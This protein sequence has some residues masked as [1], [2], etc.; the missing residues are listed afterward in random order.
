[1]AKFD[2]E[3][4]IYGKEGQLHFDN[5]KQYYETV[6]ALCN[7]DIFYITYEENKKTN[8]YADAY[9]IR[10][11]ISKEKLPLPLKNAVTS[12][13][14]I[15]C[16]EFVIQLH[17]KHD[18]NFISGQKRLRADFGQVLGTIPDRYVD[19]FQKGYWLYK[20]KYIGTESDEIF[21]KES[22]KAYH[23]ESIEAAKEDVKVHQKE[24]GTEVINVF[25]SHKHDDLE[26][27]SE[28]LGF[29]EKECGVKVYID[30]RDPEMPEVTSGET[31]MRIKSRIDSCDK[32]VLLA[33]DNAIDSKWCNWELGY[34]DAK[35]RLGQDIALLPL[36][37]NK[38]DYKG[39][40]YM[41]IYPYIVENVNEDH[42]DQREKGI[43]N[44]SV[45]IPEDDH[46]FTIISL[47]DW[48]NYS[49]NSKADEEDDDEDEEDETLW[50]D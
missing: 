34:G 15:N 49:L 28:V 46:T 33:T 31:A 2:V 40:E 21:S 11:K 43:E 13:N 3:N 29:F 41:A 23:V 42:S 47:K 19:A 8:S 39:N 7:Q 37:D 25:I 5:K 22:F 27:L 14:R 16:N 48:L 30:S 26:L 32:F 20:G 12:K 50:N 9:R 1:M 18:F 44:F 6:G 24:D 4:L 36:G 35:K 17:E 38:G 10:C 45:R